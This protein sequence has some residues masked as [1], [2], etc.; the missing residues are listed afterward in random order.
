MGCLLHACGCLLH[1]YGLS[2]ACLWVAV[3][4]PLKQCHAQSAVL[5]IT[6]DL[7]EGSKV[8]ATAQA[9][10]TGLK[11]DIEKLPDAMDIQ[12][13]ASSQKAKRLKLSGIG[14]LHDGL[15]DDDDDDLSVLS[16]A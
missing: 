6:G 8:T 1:A 10:G 12:S 4:S 13:Q 2:V 16:D 9:A 14:D 11:Y 3:R 7:E 15:E 5:L